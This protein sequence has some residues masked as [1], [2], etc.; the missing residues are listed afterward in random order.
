MDICFRFI[1]QD[2]RKSFKDALCF[3]EDKALK[4]LLVSV[5]PLDQRVSREEEVL[6]ELR[7]LLENLD[8]WAP[9]DQWA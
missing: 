4:V 2:I 8:L 7:D 6:L 5:A 1:I 9:R 3:R